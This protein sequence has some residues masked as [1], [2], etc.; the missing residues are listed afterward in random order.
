M[1]T[2]G[3]A[4]DADPVRITRGLTALAFAVLAVMVTLEIVTPGRQVVGPKAFGI[5]CVL[6]LLGVVTLPLLRRVFT[7]DG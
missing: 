3:R 4:D 2:T 6:Y 5:V 1:L 7:T